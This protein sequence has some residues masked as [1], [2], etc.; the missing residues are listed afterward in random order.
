ML[1]ESKPNFKT[2]VIDFLN[3]EGLILSEIW[4]LGFH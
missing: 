1:Q 4:L 2:T 3:P